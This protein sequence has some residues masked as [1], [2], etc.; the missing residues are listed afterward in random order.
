MLL[1]FH[2]TRKKKYNTIGRG[3][4]D[5]PL[6]LLHNHSP[7][8]FSRRDLRSKKKIFQKLYAVNPILQYH[9]SYAPVATSTIILRVEKSGNILY[10]DCRVYPKSNKSKLTYFITNY[11]DKSVIR[12]ESP[13]SIIPPIHLCCNCYIIFDS[14]IKKINVMTYIIPICKLLNIKKCFHDTFY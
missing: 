6:L 9:G 7:N 3:F 4:A 13:H 11:S 8:T 14:V 2:D 1:L 10:W 5:R 12:I